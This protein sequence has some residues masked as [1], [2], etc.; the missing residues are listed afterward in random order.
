MT[1]AADCKLAE[2]FRAKNIAKL[3]QSKETFYFRTATVID[4][5]WAGMC[6]PIK[7]I[8]CIN[9]L[10]VQNLDSQYTHQIWCQT[11]QNPWRHVHGITFV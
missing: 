4:R 8:R 9:I 7:N 3:V 5:G 2:I 10:K 6:A 1:Q 11:V